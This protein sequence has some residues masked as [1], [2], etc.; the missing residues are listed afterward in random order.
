MF[1]SKFLEV[2]AMKTKTETDTTSAFKTMTKIIR[3]WG[4]PKEQSLK[5]RLNIFV[6]PKMLNSTKHTLKN[7]W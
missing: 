4:Q 6:N 1:L 7:V 2:E 5:E 3:M